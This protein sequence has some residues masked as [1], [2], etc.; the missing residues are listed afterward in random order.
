VELTPD[1]LESLKVGRHIRI[2]P[3]LKVVI[4]RRDVENRT[5]EKL[6]GSGILFS[7][8]GFPGPTALA[9]GIPTPDEDLVIG[10]I[11]RR[12]SRESARGETIQARTPTSA[13]RRFMVTVVA[14]DD[15]ISNKLIQ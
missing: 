10:S 5:L 8:V 15:W 9:H 4:S 14:T 6:S 11:I 12:Y 13:P 3:G 2:R 1:V 7:P